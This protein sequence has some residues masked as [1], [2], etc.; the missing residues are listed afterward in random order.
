MKQHYQIGEAVHVVHG[1]R[2]GVVAEFDF[3]AGDVTPKGADEE[4]VLQHLVATGQA[5]LVKPK[6]KKEA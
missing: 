5:S 4:A 1:L 2:P 6:Q 3:E